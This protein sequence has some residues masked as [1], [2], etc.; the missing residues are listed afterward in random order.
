MVDLAE[1]VGGFGP[2]NSLA[3]E[4]RL[5]RMLVERGA[6]PAPETLADLNV[7]LKGLLRGGAATKSFN[8]LLRES[9]IGL[10]ELVGRE[11]EYQTVTTTRASR[12]YYPRQGS[13]HDRS[14]TGITVHRRPETG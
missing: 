11:R 7:K 9:Q 8:G 1:C 10:A 13:A 6:S 2:V 12:Q 3:K 4:T 14:R 5:A